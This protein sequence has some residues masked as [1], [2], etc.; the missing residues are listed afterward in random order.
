MQF[1][2]VPSNI[3]DTLIA[4]DRHILSYDRFGNTISDEN[5]YHM[6]D[7]WNW[8]YGYKLDRVYDTTVTLS[9]VCDKYHREYLYSSEYKYNNKILYDVWSYDISTDK[10][11]PLIT[12]DTLRY[13]CFAGQ[14]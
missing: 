6:D 11:I 8:T 10:G 12:S 7:S 2:E 4:T 3:N 13:Y 9:S 5:E 14:I 1:L